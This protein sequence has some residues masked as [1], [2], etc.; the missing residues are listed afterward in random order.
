MNKT[1]NLLIALVIILLASCG[2]NKKTEEVSYDVYEVKVKTVL[3]VR[4]APTSKSE[5]IGYVKN[6]SYIPVVSISDGWAK[7][8]DGNG[9]CGYVAADYLTL[10]QKMKSENVEE[11]NIARESP[12]A[13]SSGSKEA[14]SG[15]V[16]DG[17]KNKPEDSSINKDENKASERNVSFIGDA[18]ILT[19]GQKAE[20]EGILHNCDEYLFIINTVDNVAT[21]DLFDY[22]PDLLKELSKNMDSGMSWWKRFKSYFSGDAPSSNV[23]LLSYV[24]SAKL[25]QAECNGNSLKY[26]RMERPDTY[27][28]IQADARKN[29]P[30]AISKLGTEISKAGKEYESRSWYIRGQINSGNILNNICD[31]VIVQ[32]ILPKNSFWHKWVF[33]WIFAIP[34]AIANFFFALTNSY[35]MTIV[36]FMIIIVSLQYFIVNKL[37][38]SKDSDKAIALP[39]MLAKFLIWLCMIS[40]LVYMIPDMTNISVMEAS[41]Y[42]RSVIKSAIEDYF[43][44]HI[45]KN[46]FLILIF[47]LGTAITTGVDKD[48]VL[49]ATLPSDKQC[50]LLIQYRKNLEQSIQDFDYSKYQQLDTPFESLA[51]EK[52]GSELGKILAT[53][54]PLS[55]VFSGTLLLYASVFLWTKAFNKIAYIVKGIFTYKERGLYR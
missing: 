34:F 9:H 30:A 36:L 46:W 47:I 24:K 54:L 53:T 45:T 4:A 55:F 52:F 23:V 43:T 37:F 21:G 22:A 7:I 31:E 17:R 20:I 48:L 15:K 6:G 44:S 12:S 32:N 35:M 29:L 16:A 42:S 5:I 40:L 10:V 3:N 18:S 1:V 25:L 41:G 27:F 11:E 13:S 26:L 49:F 38:S 8:E 39:V 19:A 33:G 14:P 28:S 50:A 2:T 51:A